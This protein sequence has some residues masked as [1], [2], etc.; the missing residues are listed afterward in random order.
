MSEIINPSNY[1]GFCF[2]GEG[3]SNFVISAKSHKDGIRIVWRLSKDRKT[4]NISLKPKCHVVNAYL[5]NLISHFLDEKFLIKPKL[6]HIK[7][8]DAHHLAKIPSLTHNL[9]IDSWEDLLDIKEYPQNLSFLPPSVMLNQEIKYISAL[10]MPDATRIPKRLPSV[11]PTITF[12]IKPK[13][14][15][16]QLHPGISLPFCNNCILQIE[17]WQTGNFERMYDF[18]PLELYSGDLNRM[19]AAIMSLIREPHKNLRIFLDGNLIHSEETRLPV[20]GMNMACFPDGSAEVDTLVEALCHVLS[21]VLPSLLKAQK[22]DSI[23][24]VRAMEIYNNLPF[25]IQ[26]E[27]LD[28]KNLLRRGLSILNDIDPR[29]LLERYLLSGIFKDVSVM[30]SMRRVDSVCIANSPAPQNIVSILSPSST[31]NLCFAYSVRIVDL[32]PKTPKNLINAFQRFN[33][34]IRMIQ[35]NG[36]IH[37]PCI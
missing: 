11:G 28:K 18:C 12:E 35:A 5:E 14:G 10:E 13:Q 19:H 20:I 24:I 7:I 16:Y 21:N 4:G 27:L 22:L 32:D 23:G 26:E 8:D 37:K 30:V 34:G 1:Y 33:D 29:S 15:F 25:S 6:V 9:K 3:R 17:K 36:N 31:K 2:R